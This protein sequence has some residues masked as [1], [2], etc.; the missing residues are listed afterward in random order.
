M[1]GLDS[2]TKL[3]LHCN[4]SDEST[5]FTDSSDSGHTVTAG[6]DAQV[7]TAQKKFGTGSVLFDGTSDYLSVANSSEFDLDDTES[8]TIDYWVRLNASP[9]SWTCTMHRGLT[10]LPYTGWMISFNASG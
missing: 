6:G 10:S 5:T 8:W 4:G 2:N 1:A 3:L 9:S 7:D